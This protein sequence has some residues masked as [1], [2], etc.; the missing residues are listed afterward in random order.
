MIGNRTGCRHR[1]L[2]VISNANRR[3]NMVEAKFSLSG[4]VADEI[5]VKVGKLSGANVIFSGSYLVSGNNIF[6]IARLIIDT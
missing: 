4:L 6:V 3:N 2:S 1:N 5:M